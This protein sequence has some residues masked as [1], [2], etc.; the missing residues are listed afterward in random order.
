MSRKTCTFPNNTC[1][2]KPKQ[3]PKIMALFNTV[4]LVNEIPTCKTCWAG[5]A[6]FNTAHG[7]R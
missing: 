4:L 1:K 5:T 2:Y 6:A 3:T 7:S